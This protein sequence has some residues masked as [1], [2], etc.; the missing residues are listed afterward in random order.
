LKQGAFYR[1]RRTRVYCGGAAAAHNSGF[2][3]RVD[4]LTR[5]VGTGHVGIDYLEKYQEV[6]APGV[7]RWRTQ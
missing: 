3:D 4:H 1:G 5:F 2:G 6:V 7:V